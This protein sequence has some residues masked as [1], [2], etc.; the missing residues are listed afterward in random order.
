MKLKINQ[1]IFE[2]F[3]G[4][5]M[6]VIVVKDVDNSGIQKDILEKIKEIEQNIRKDY[7]TETLLQNPK[8]ECWRKAYSLFGGE[9]KKNKS[10]IESLYRRILSGEE[11]RHINK[12]VDIYNLISIKYMLPVGGEDLN[13]IKGDIELTF[14]GSEEPLVALLGDKEA[15]Q[16]HEGEVIYKDAISAICR[17]FNWREADRTKLTEKTT[18]C[19]LV[20]EALPPSTKEELYKITLEL[21]ELIEKQCQGKIKYTILNENEHEIEL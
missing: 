17:R 18:N 16:P 6:G 15:R 8:I 11:L 20:I 19:I 13:K 21:K 12:L 9:P 4:L 5:N 1:K 7:K 10:S 14:A 2:R 3:P